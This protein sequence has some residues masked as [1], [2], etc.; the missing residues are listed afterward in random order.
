MICGT[1]KLEWC[2]NKVVKKF[3]A[4]FEILHKWDV[5]TDGQTGIA[6]TALARSASR[7]KT[8]NLQCRERCKEELCASNGAWNSTSCWRNRTCSIS[9]CPAACHRRRLDRQSFAAAGRKLISGLS[10]HGSDAS[11]SGCEADVR[12]RQCRP[13]SL[14]HRFNFPTVRCARCA[15]ARQRGTIESSATVPPWQRPARLK[16]GQKED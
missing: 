7:S 11:P 16:L 9:S 5:Q 6:H 1:I 14:R 10:G 12:F 2:G 13:F 3:D 8:V 15:F 4:R